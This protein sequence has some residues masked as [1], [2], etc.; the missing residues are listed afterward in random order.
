MFLVGFTLLSQ[1]VI[2]DDLDDLKATNERYMNAWN[3]RDL[4]TLLEIEDASGFGH[5]SAFPR[6]LM[7]KEQLRKLYTWYFETMDLILIRI[8]KDEHRVIGNTGLVWGHYSQ[9]TKQKNGPVRTVYVRHASTYV[10]SEGKWKLVLYHRSLIP[11]E[12]IP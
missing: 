10:K 6:P 12:E 2:A 5:S 7:D 11:S 3:T 9:A 1:P 4:D 8:Y